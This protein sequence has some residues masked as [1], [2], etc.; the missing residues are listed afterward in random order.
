[1][2]FDFLTLNILLRFK[3]LTYTPYQQQTGI[4]I[5]EVLVIRVLNVTV[6]EVFY[7]FKA[8]ANRRISQWNWVDSPSSRESLIVQR[9][10]RISRESWTANEKVAN[11]ATESEEPCTRSTSD[12]E[13]VQ[14]NATEPTNI[15]TLA[16]HNNK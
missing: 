2:D 3:T 14:L 6:L 12:I 9:N 13:K 7:V 5:P 8:V 1:M 16:I 10:Y 11:C 4:Y 15:C